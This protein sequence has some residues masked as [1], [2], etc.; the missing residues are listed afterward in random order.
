MKSSTNTKNEED[1]KEVLGNGERLRAAI[2]DGKRD[3]EGAT[4]RKMKLQ[5]MISDT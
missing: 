5:G 2:Y 4:D 1:R 3:R